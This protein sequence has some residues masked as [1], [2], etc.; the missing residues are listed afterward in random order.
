MDGE[1]T[2]VA[3]FLDAG[4]P[5]AVQ[6]DHDRGAAG[7]HDGLVV[8]EH[9]VQLVADV[10]GV[11][12]PLAGALGV[13]VDDA[14][15]RGDASVERRVGRIG[16]QLVVLDEVDPGPGEPGHEL[17]RRLRA[18]AH[19]RLD[20]RPDERPRLGDIGEAT[21]SRDAETGAGEVLGEGARD[22]EVLEPEA[23]DLGELVEVPLQGGDERGQVV[24][25]VLD[26][27]ADDHLGLAIA[28][29]ALL[30]P[31]PA[32]GQGGPIDDR[33]LRDTLDAGA[34]A[35]AD[36]LRLARDVHEGAR[37]LLPGQDGGG[38]RDVQGRLDQVGG[39]DAVGSH[40]ESGITLARSPAPAQG[41]TMARGAIRQR[42]SISRYGW[43]TTGPTRP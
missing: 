14:H 32:T 34:E 39:G 18:Q 8:V 33:L 24:S 10:E 36:V 38:L 11:H 20:D 27:P 2:L 19:A 26:A 21:G 25:D 1:G 7:V 3:E 13:L 23:G 42:I 37:G 35:V 6:A 5:H 12:D 4:E 16:H 15:H 28:P 43:S 31:C 30:V 9:R 41:A 40:R 22:I 29:G 17:R